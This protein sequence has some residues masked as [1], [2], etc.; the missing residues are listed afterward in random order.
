MHRLIASLFFFFFCAEVKT[1]FNYGFTNY[2]MSGGLPDNFVNCLLQDN[3]GFM[4]FGTREGLSRYDGTNF[5][6]YFT[7]RNDS[8]ALPG[9]NIQCLTEYKPG[10]LLFTASGRL[11]AFNSVTQQFHQPKQVFNKTIFYLNAAGNNSWFIA[12][13]DTCLVINSELDIVDTLLPPLKNRGQT[14]YAHIMDDTTWLTGSHNEYFIY[15][16]QKRKFEPFPIQT[17]LPPERQFFLFHYYDKKN[18]QLYFSNFWGGLYR[19][20]LTGRLLRHW[21][22]NPATGLANTNIAFVRSKNDSILWVGTLGGGL[23]ILNTRTDLF[24]RIVS[25]KMNPRS[26]PGNVIVMNYT[27][28][29]LNEWIAT[30]EGV[31]KIHAATAVITSWQTA[32]NRLSG[33]ISLLHVKKGND[34]NMYIAAYSSNHA[35][36]I[37]AATSELTVLDPSRLPVT[38]CL[39]SFGNEL[40]FTGSGTAVTKFNPLTG[41]YTKSDF[42]KKYFP[43]A[44]MVVLAFKHSNGDEWYSGNNGGGFVRISAKDGTVHSYK[45]D[46]PNGKFSISYYLFHVED[47]DG[48]LWFGVNKTDKLLFWNKQ[49]D[50]FTEIQLSAAHGISDQVLGGISCMTIDGNNHLWIAFEGAGLVRYDIGGNRAEHYTIQEGLPTNFIYSLQFDG[51]NR[52]WVGTT[53]GLS[54]FLVAQ[55]KF[56]NFSKEHGLPDD[57]FTEHCVFFDSAAN[58]LWI[59]TATTLMTFNPDVL[60]SL[61]KKPLPVYIDQLTVNGRARVAND[62]GAISFRAWENNL[63]F[64]FIGLD[65]NDGRDIEYSY[66]LAGGD[67]EWIYNGDIATASFA[68]LLPGEYTFSVKARHKGDNEWT[69]MQH[70]VAFVIEPHWWQ[71]WWFNLL[72]VAGIMWLVVA[73]VKAWFARKLQKQKIIMEKELAIEQ[74]RTRMARELHDG[75]GSMLSGIKHSFAAIQNQL[76]LDSNQQVLFHANIDKLNETIKELRNISHSMASDSLLK[77]GLENSL[78]DYCQ[79]ITQTGELKVSFTALDTQQLQLSEEQ[80]FHIFR[81]VQELLWN[82][83]KHAATDAAILQISYNAK[84][85]YIAVEDSGKGFELKTVHQKGGMGLKNIESRI[86]ILKGRMDYRSEPEKGTSVL[87]EIP[88]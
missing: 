57:H 35:Y 40:I 37:N 24:K 54:C 39:N 17:S 76:Q 67:N 50:R 46:G 33:D 31:G 80:V 60:L 13:T 82:I 85:L 47:K 32:F 61:H 11:T 12:G 64:Y 66:Q 43:T 22:Y 8:T 2:F 44:E 45:K 3:R 38:W 49:T 42:L 78:R 10:Q 5:R 41:Q 27:D 51:K 65:I 58:K 7:R 62:T 34:G 87:I 77:Y 20:S 18:K 88:V 56:V 73:F 75:L 36:K 21:D 1:Q 26:L 70:P 68:H 23:H 81:I 15:H 48:N 69:F 86:R 14:V 55:K 63:Q 6:N 74:E 4:W 29:D 28:R 71:T 72:L 16:T 53:K 84:R 30:T 25:D 59:G 52:L 9:N 83:I 79:N 19:Y